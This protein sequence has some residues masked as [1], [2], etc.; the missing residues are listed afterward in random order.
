MFLLSFLGRQ[1]LEESGLI[2]IP[3]G[4]GIVSEMA[5]RAQ[6]DEPRVR[7]LRIVVAMRGGESPSVRLERLSWPSTP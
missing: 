2:R 4:D 7:I 3:A 6:S 5:R 1:Q